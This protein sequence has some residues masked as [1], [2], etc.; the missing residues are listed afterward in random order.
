[1]TAT[2]IAEQSDKQ[3]R[4]WMLYDW[5]NSAFATTILAA[6]FP[7]YYSAV[8]GST[9]PSAAK[10]TQYYSLTLSASVLVV[11]IISPILGTL[12]DTTGTRK[13]WLVGFALVGAAATAGLFTVGE[14]AW[15][16]ASLVFV[17]ARIGFGGSSV[18]Y[19][20]LLPHVAPPE[21]IDEVSSKGFALGYLGGGI[22]LAINVAMIFALPDDNLGVRL[23]FVTVGIWW[24]V[25]SIPLIRNVT[26]PVG[27]AG[28][29]IAS[30]SKAV[31][32]E[33]KATRQTLRSLPEL[34]RFLLGFL[35]Y[36]DAI[37]IVI[38]V[39]A[40]YGAELGFGAIELTL[41]ILLVQFVGIP[42]SLLFGSIP[43]GSTTVTR[44]R[45]LVAFVLANVV[46]LPTTAIAM[47]QFGPLEVSGTAPEAYGTEG[48]QGLPT[49]ASAAP[50]SF[51]W[52]GRSLEITYDA[53][54]AVADVSLRVDGEAWLDDDGDVVL[55]GD[56]EVARTGEA[57]VIDPGAAGEHTIEFVTVGQAAFAPVAEVEILPPP[58]ESNLGLIIALILGVQ[59]V[60]GL[61]AFAAGPLVAPIADR[62]GTKEA[63]LLA[64]A[65][66]LIVAVWGFRLDSVVEFWGLAWLVAICQGG[67]QALSRSLFTQLIPADRSGEFFGFFSVISKFASLLS[68]LVFVASVA[69]FD[70]SRPAVLALSVFF[71]IGGWLLWGVDVDAGVRRIGKRATPSGEN[72]REWGP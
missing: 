62:M 71:V 32:A 41:A 14:G 13:R 31:V 56:G 23:S 22:L 5:A 69:L 42:Y 24:A 45:R 11:A 12:A 33:L 28:A 16:W 19:D 47:R 3:V 43:G 66:Y 50:T 59:V 67:S 29:T 18:F 48:V 64:L 61:F 6:V 68:P 57:I 30:A 39:A 37:G 35:I 10:A 72:L 60:A 21:R 25:F 44:R 46:L 58:R 63:I 52:S 26:E 40:I 53:G 20:S 65:A 17:V 7:V 15:L 1:M 51:D 49:R 8:A 54:P 55:L 2:E 70:S 4:S 34:G 38:S 27:R 36:N 9:L